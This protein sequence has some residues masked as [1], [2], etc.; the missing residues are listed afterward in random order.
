MENLNSLPYSVVM[1]TTILY[2]IRKTQQ[3][4][5]PIEYKREQRTQAKLH[6]ISCHIGFAFVYHTEHL[7]RNSIRM[8]HDQ[9][10]Y[11]S[12]PSDRQ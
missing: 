11:F 12:V 4:Y 6:Q 5:C 7:I 9:T 3:R 1:L 10:Q 8:L 2:T